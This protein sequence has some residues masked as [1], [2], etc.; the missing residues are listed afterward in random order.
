MSN[1]YVGQRAKYAG[2]VVEILGEQGHP[3]TKDWRLKVRSVAT[4]RELLAHPTLLKPLSNRASARRG[5]EPRVYLGQIKQEFEKAQ[6]EA[7]DIERGMA[8]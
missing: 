5:R 6:Q 7:A 2:D 3:D 4:G 8:S 1:Y